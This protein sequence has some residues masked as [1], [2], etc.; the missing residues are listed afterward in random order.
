MKSQNKLI[1]KCLFTVILILTF[2]FY[3]NQST[4]AQSSSMIVEYADSI[5]TIGLDNSTILD[6]KTQE[7]DSMI[8]V[9]Y[10]ESSYEFYPQYSENLS[11]IATEVTSRIIIDY[12]DSITNLELIEPEYLDQA[13]SGPKVTVNSP[14]GNYYNTS[15]EL[16]VDFEDISGLDSAYYKVDSYLPIGTDILGWFEI[17]SNYGGNNFTT[18]FSMDIDLWNSLND[19]SHLV[20][21]KTWD[22]SGN[23]ID[24]ASHSWQFYKDTTAPT[25][26]INLPDGIYYAESPTMDVDFSDLAGLDAAYY[27]VDSYTPIGMDTTGW[28]QIFDIFGGTFYTSDFTLDNS[29][30]AFLSEGSHIMYFKVWDDLG[31][32]NDG[33]T[34]SWQFYKDSIAPSIIVNTSNENYYTSPPTFKV[35]FADNNSLD[36]AYFKIDSYAPTGMDTTGW[37]QIFSDTSNMSY[38][39][40]IKINNEMWNSLDDSLYRIYFKCWDD[41][42]NINDGSSPFWQFF[43]YSGIPLI[44]IN[45]P[46]GDYYNSSPIMDV[47]FFD[48]TGLDAAY[49]RVDSYL[50]AGS[51]TI[52]WT[53]IFD[54]YNNQNFTNNVIMDNSIWLSLSEG[55]HIV[56]FKVWNNSGIINDGSTPSWQFYKDTIPP[57]ISL[58]SPPE[59]GIYQSIITV[60]INVSGHSNFYYSW[61]NAPFTL[62]TLTTFNL[63]ND[64][65]IHTLYIKAVDEA[66]N[67]ASSSHTF[68]IDNIPPSAEVQGMRDNL[69]I[70]SIITIRVTPYDEYGI[71][72]ISFYLGS[73]LLSQQTSDYIY[74][75]DPSMYS[76]GGYIFTIEIEDLAGNILSRDFTINIE[77]PQK[78]LWQNLMEQGILIPIIGAIF[79]GIVGVV[80]VY[81]KRKLKK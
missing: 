58:L 65:G 54:N 26:T 69:H 67:M 9:E 13:L 47:D 71:N 11:N 12:A 79:T 18:D 23:I 4:I 51:D 40:N 8:I 73:Q 55:S 62:T 76:Y 15:P 61:D 39:A 7:I 74:R 46:S 19:G 37:T 10:A 48:P 2:Q 59:N 63:P 20:Y 6:N 60:Q 81:I 57:K 66:G 50:P 70:S 53:Q 25:I 75:F 22:D 64:D 16:D 38:T 68:I 44:N 41:V 5:T 78:N 80:F 72:H 34:P 35:Y 1:S 43:K 45:T 14:N 24:G 28:I 17:F 3:I 30:W 21:F 49:Y 27:K 31:N 36:S 33:D 52:G 56:Y 29:I 42:G 32:I 77:E